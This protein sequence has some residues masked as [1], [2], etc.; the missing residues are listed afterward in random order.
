[1]GEEPMHQP[2]SEFCQQSNPSVWLLPYRHSC[3]AVLQSRWVAGLS[4][5]ARE[6]QQGMETVNAGR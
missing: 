5:C 1:M 4:S 6:R 2:L 3:A